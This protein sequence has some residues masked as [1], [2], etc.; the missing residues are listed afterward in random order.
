VHTLI[1]TDGSDGAIEAARRGLALLAAADRVTILSVVEPP[2]AATAG[3]ESGFAGGVVA[4]EQVDEAW[5]LAQQEADAAIDRTLEAIGG[6][7]NVERA[8]EVGGAGP[9]ICELAAER[10][11]DVV[12]VG[13]RGRGAVKRALL[14]SVSS[15]VVHN[16]PCPVLV[17]RADG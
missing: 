17:V 6:I 13:S 12:I 4:P 15:H 1:A 16:A 2:A 8:A 7:A 5:A 14:G 11:V 10:G 9:V 3:L